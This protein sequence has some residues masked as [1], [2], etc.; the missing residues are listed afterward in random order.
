MKTILITGASSGFGE[1]TAKLLAKDGHRIM[2]VARRGDRLEALKKQ[3]KTEV[4]TATLDVTSKADVKKF[5]EALPR[6][7]QAVDVL[8]NNAGLALG[9]T[10]AQDSNLEDWERMVDTNI[11]GLLYMTHHA[12][13]V[14]RQNGSGHIV[15]IASTAAYFP[16][17]GGNVYGGTKAFVAQ[18]SRNLRTDLLGTN[19]RVSSIEPGAAETEFSIVRL[20]DK[21]A[22]DT[23]YKGWRPLTPEDVAAS[24]KWVV[25]QPPHVSITSLQLV[26]TDQAYGGQEIYKA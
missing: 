14:M 12:L 9:M 11:K 6:D 13:E 18:F 23:F 22:A 15:N 10:P 3:L 16:Y 19:I 7:F 2:L 21:Q 4:Y 20:R 26:S 25:D 17:K 24:V 1:A 8:V 5:F